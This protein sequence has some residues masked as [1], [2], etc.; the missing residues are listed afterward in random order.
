MTVKQRKWQEIF[1]AAL[2]DKLDELHRTN[3]IPRNADILSTYS[4]QCAEDWYEKGEDPVKAANFVAMSLVRHQIINQIYQ[5]SLQR[6]D[7]ADPTEKERIGKC[8]HDAEQRYNAVVGSNCFESDCTHKKPLTEGVELPNMI[9]WGRGYGEGTNPMDTS[10]ISRFNS[11]VARNDPYTGSI[12]P[13]LSRIQQFNAN[14][15][16]KY[17][18]DPEPELD[19]YVDTVFIDDLGPEAFTVNGENPYRVLDKIRAGEDFDIPVRHGVAVKPSLPSV[20]KETP[21]EEPGFVETFDEIFSPG[22]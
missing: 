1:D 16:S 4:T 2:A 14:N 8:L 7:T 3:Q 6:R 20:V 11:L 21:V 9:C 15:A 10:V 18:V 13:V 12:N 19:K 17:T 22:N 5:L